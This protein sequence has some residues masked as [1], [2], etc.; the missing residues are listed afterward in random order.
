[1]PRNIVGAP[2][3]GDDFFGRDDVVAELIARTTTGSLLLV[4]PRRWGKTSVLRAFRDGDAEHRHYFDLY[5]V[6]TPAAFVA[7]IAA[8]S[9]G[10]VSQVRSWLGRALGRVFSSVEQVQ[11]GEVAIQLRE[12]IGREQGWVEAAHALFQSFPP[13]HV[14]LFDEFQVMVKSVM[15]RDVPE[16]RQLLRQ[17]RFERQRA[18][19]PRMVFA[20]S[21]SLAE[22]CRQAG[23]SDTINDLELL[24]LH[25]FSR[26]AAADLLRGMF[27]TE[28]VPL[29]EP[30][31]EAILEHVGPEVPF[32][33]QI[34]TRA[35]LA[36]ARDRRARTTAR[37]VQRAYQDVLL[38]AEYRT[39][40][41]DFRG[42][43]D[44]AYLS[45]ERRA[46]ILV[47][48]ALAADRH[49]L[50]DRALQMQLVAH[51]VDDRVLDRV[52]ALLQGDFYIAQGEDGA[53]RFLNRYLADWWM[54]FRG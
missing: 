43:L 35:L 41:D 23:L 42:R 30:A 19:G 26:E 5:H 25:P 4:A 10:G 1:M 45:E 39:Y 27:R 34:M 20:G 54:R 51:G 17:L 47:L 7:E 13:G 6:D 16:A 49:G 46:A 28:G 24:V 48:D 36:E 11:I 38:G 12:Q 37:T 21:T 29:Q 53:Y 18:D 15:D 31:L 40:L 52:L 50:P 9:A 8:G 33:L 3:S 32:F 2:V 22:L 44:R 14:L